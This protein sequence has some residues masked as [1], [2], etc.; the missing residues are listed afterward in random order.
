MPERHLPAQTAMDDQSQQ[1]STSRPNHRSRTSA[2]AIFTVALSA[3]ALLSWVYL[4]MEAIA[5][6]DQETT[7]G[8]RFYWV[9]PL[10]S[11]ELDDM[12]TKVRWARL[13][14]G[15]K[16]QGVFIQNNMIDPVR[17][18]RALRHF[19]SVRDLY[20]SSDTTDRVHA[21]L[22][23]I[24]HQPHLG[25]L[26]V[27]EVPPLD[28]RLIPVIGK[29]PALVRIYVTHSKIT[30]EGFPRLELLEEC[31]LDF[32]PVTDA[33]LR[34]ILQCPNLAKVNI[35]DSRVTESAVREVL[36]LD[37]PKLSLFNVSSDSVSFERLAFLLK[38]ARDA[39]PKSQL[40][41]D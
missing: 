34:A 1:P 5:A 21:L 6:V 22:A 9:T 18:G 40:T 36:K 37:R 39:N 31:T 41:L 12:E 33:G 16:L 3:F 23:Q 29:C 20:V 26:Q 4:R 27:D 15:T 7:G 28:D 11:G 25:D 13:L 19:G 14:P 30:G 32:A 10:G 24:G 17:L 8:K 35:Q 38:E 2:I